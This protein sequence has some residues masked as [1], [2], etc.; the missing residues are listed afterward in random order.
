MFW[1]NAKSTPIERY[2]LSTKLMVLYVLSTLSILSAVCLFLY[3]TFLTVISQLGGAHAEDIKSLCY[4]N[5]V[6]ALLFSSIGAIALGKIVANN[7][8]NQLQVFADTIQKISADSLH[9]RIHTQDWPNE[10]KGLGIEFNLMLDRIQTSFVQ[11]TQFSSDIAHELRNPLNNLQG[12]TEVALAKEKLP[13][14]YSKILESYMNEYQHLTKLVE[15]LLF[16][17]RSDQHQLTMNKTLINTRKEILKII[18]YYQIIAESKKVEVTCHGDEPLLVDVTLFKRIINNLLSNSLKY[19]PDEGKINFLIKSKPQWVEITIHDTGIGI[20]E[21][22]LS[23][24]F[25]RFYRADPSRSPESGGLG[26]GLAIVKSIVELHQGKVNLVSKLNQGT[27][28]QL[29]FPH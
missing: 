27:T 2:S 9:E 29:H 18:D 17:A 5:I 19:T 4:K 1:K 20:D 8:L 12:I 11:L 23:K 25:N 7:G 26:L 24:I 13:V 14:E 10:L 21:S 28:I 22:H 3:P 16:L 6:I 15:S